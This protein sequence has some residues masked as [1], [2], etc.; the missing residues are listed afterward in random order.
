MES[1]ALIWITPPPGPTAVLKCCGS[2]SRST[3]QSSTCASISV[4]AG[5][6]DQIIPCAPS[7]ADTSSA[8]IDG[9]DAFAGNHA[10]Q[11]GDCQCVMPGSTISSRSRISASNGSGSSGACAGSFARISPGSTPGAIGSSPTRSM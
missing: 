5:L 10:N 6:D 8:R 11:P 4:S 1:D 3:S 2:P 9:G 7:P